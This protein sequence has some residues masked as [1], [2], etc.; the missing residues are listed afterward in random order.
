MFGCLFGLIRR[1]GCLILLALLA[2]A[3]YQWIVWPDVAELAIRDPRSTAFID[4]YRDYAGRDASLHW[5]WVGYGRISK[6]LKTA[7]L[8]GEDIDF[9]SHNGFAV[10][11]LKTAVQET[12]LEGEPLRGASTISQQTVKNLWLSPSR[13]PWRKVKE[14]AL[15]LQLERELDKRR[16]LEIYLNVAEFAPGTYGAEAAALRR[17][18]RSAGSLSPKQAAELAACLPSPTSCGAEG[19]DD[20]YRERVER[21]RRRVTRADWLEAEL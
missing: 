20:A 8:V 17:Y 18:G 7:V 6:E 4:L 1:A 2:F 11:E 21:I 15:T 12:V 14:A 16:I 19:G 5:Q 10:E 13:N 3:G 9:F